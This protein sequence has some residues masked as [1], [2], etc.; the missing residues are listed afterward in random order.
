M[1]F[2][3]GVAR[4]DDSPVIRVCGFFKFGRKWLLGRRFGPNTVSGAVVAEG[5]A[6]GERHHAGVAFAQVADHYSSEVLAALA[7]DTRTA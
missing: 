2:E 4:F 5:P 3:H 7:A 1:V 6:A